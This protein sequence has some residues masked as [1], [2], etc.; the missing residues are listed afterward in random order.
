MT[1]FLDDDP[2]FTHKVQVDSRI[3]VVW[4]CEE[5]YAKTFL[6][7]SA[8]DSHGNNL[9]EN[10]FLNDDLQFIERVD[11]E[12][13]PDDEEMVEWMEKLGS[14]RTDQVT[15]LLDQLKTWIRR[16]YAPDILPSKIYFQMLVKLHQTGDTKATRVINKEIYDQFRN[17]PRGFTR[18]NILHFCSSFIDSALYGKMLDDLKHEAIGNEVYMGN[19]SYFLYRWWWRFAR[20]GGGTA[21]KLHAFEQAVRY[22]PND[23]MILDELSNWISPTRETLPRLVDVYFKIISLSDG[24]RP[25]NWILLQELTD[26]LCNE[27]EAQNTWRRLAS[28]FRENGQEDRAKIALEKAGPPREPC[29]DALDFESIDLDIW[30]E[31]RRPR[32]V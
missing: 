30:G 7:L 5:E 26:D 13:P 10:V 4:D 19:E 21:G 6:R 16:D 9:M 22:A 27:Y 20:E 28:R 11:K 12:P 15:R 18:Q 25:G 2:R 29:K 8:V 31:K 3:G 14:D 1:T 23:F 24:N 17:K 32:G